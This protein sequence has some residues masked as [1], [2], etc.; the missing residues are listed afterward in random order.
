MIFHN[1]QLI[2]QNSNKLFQ[3]FMYYQYYLILIILLFL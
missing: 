3:D 2:I 1:Y